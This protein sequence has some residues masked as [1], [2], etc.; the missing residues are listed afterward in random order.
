MIRLPTTIARAAWLAFAASALLS[1]SACTSYEKPPVFE[2]APYRYRLGPQDAL[3]VTVWGRPEL[4]TEGDVAPD[5]RFAMPLAGVVPVLGLTLEEAADRLAAQLK[6]YVRDPIVTVEL[7]DLKSAQIHVGGEVR[8]PGSV[9]FHDGMSVIEAIQRSGS[10]IDEFANKN[11]VFLVRDAIGAKRIFEIDIE[12]VL[13][14]PD[15]EHDVMVQ[16]GDIVYV[17]PRYVTQFARWI[18]QAMAPF[19]S[20]TGVARNTAYTATAIPRPF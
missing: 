9:A 1:T 12:S 4:L 14:E 19:E 10:W 6:E 15:G 18:H 13:T 3:R 17:P 11:R 20:L 2:R 16:A 5:G 7:R 8:V